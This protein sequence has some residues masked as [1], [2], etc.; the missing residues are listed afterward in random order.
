L[1]IN[2]I[3]PAFGV[4][5]YCR[6]TALVSGDRAKAINVASQYGIPEGSVYDYRNYEQL[7]SNPNVHVIYIVLPNGMHEEYLVRGAKTGK[8]ILCEKPMANSAAEAQRMIDAC[9]K[10]NIK[11]MIAYR[12]QYESNNQA[13]R[14]L[15][16]QGN[17]GQLRGFIS[18]NS[19]PMGDP[20]HWRLKKTLAGGGCLPDIG[21]YCINASRFISGEEPIRA[22][23][24]LWQRKG[25][26]RFA[27]V[28]A[29]VSFSMHFSFEFIAICSTSYDVHKSQTLRLEGTDMWVEMSPA[30]AYHRIRLKLSRLEEGQQI[31]VQP[32]IEDKGSVCFG[33]GLLRPLREHRPA[34]T[35][36]W[37]GRASG[38][39]RDRGNLRSGP[40]R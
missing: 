14:R 40:N 29:S 6:P 2:Q 22:T 27:E 4:S 13:V 25:D 9:T 19:Q 17:L 12:Q 3:L 35:Y 36:T 11:L 28:E 24:Q 32:E 39:S 8:H 38:S 15:V 23:A 21:I 7:A 33:D 1:L 5:K 16:T 31:S 18:T 20:T 26:P 10:A 37:E 30:C 34:P